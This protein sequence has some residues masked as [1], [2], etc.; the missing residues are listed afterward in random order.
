MLREGSISTISFSTS[1]SEF[2]NQTTNS[3][4]KLF[5]SRVTQSYNDKQNTNKFQIFYLFLMHVI[6]PRYIGLNICD[7][8]EY[9]VFY[10]ETIYLQSENLNILPTRLI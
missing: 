8:F 2:S 10:R 3:V 6:T 1:I 9:T 5:E 7:N 4:I